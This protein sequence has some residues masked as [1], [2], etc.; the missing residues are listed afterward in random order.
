MSKKQVPYRG[1]CKDCKYWKTLKC[2]ELKQL[3]KN[4]QRDD[5]CLGGKYKKGIK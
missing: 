3:G 1:T 5:N 4:P 2:W